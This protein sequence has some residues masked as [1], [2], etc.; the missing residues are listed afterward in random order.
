MEERLI[1]AL[2]VFHFPVLLQGSM[3]PNEPYPDSFFTF[4][5]DASD[6]ESFYSNKEH[7]I[8]WE[9]SLNFY[10]SDPNLVNSVLMDAKEALKDAGFEAYGAGYSVMS[11]QPTHTGRG[12][13]IIYREKF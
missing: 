5:N 2:E 9:Y 6:G 7:M 8:L 4:W 12:I 11:D 1:Q 3:L 10:S 13:T